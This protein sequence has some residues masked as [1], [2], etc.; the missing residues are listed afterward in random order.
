MFNKMRFILS[1]LCIVLANRGLAQSINI[2]STFTYAQGEG[3]F[4]N[5]GKGEGTKINLLTTTQ[6]GVQYT[7]IPSLVATPN[8][9]RMSLNLVRIAVAASTYKNKITMGLV[10]DFTGTTPILEAWAGYKL[11]KQAKIIFGQKQTHT[12]NRLAMEDE[13]FAQVMSQSI[14]GTSSDGIMYGGLMHNFVG[15]TREAGLYVETNFNVGKMRVYP[16]ASL[17]TGRGQNF[18]DAYTQGGYK[19]GGRLDIMPLGDFIKNNAF[20][21]HDIYRE[22]KPRLALGVAASVNVNASNADGSSNPNVVGIF[23]KGGKAGFANYRKLVADAMFKYKGFAMVGEYMVGTVAGADLF[24][25]TAATNKLTEEVASGYYNL[26][27][28]FN[29]QTSY[30][31]KKGLAIDGR[32]TVVTPEFE[33]ASSRV[34]KQ[35]WVTLGINK[36]LKRNALKVGIN[37]SYIHNKGMVVSNEQWVGN[38]AVQLLL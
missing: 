29:M 24:T 19:Y 38:F 33:M 16:S 5:L 3:V 26:G 21:A 2:D 15:S 28:A 7:N 6:P 11:S 20:I 22:M 10:T 37:V 31:F 32:F 13:R 36:Y 23:K 9:T 34:N 4:I 27:S 8:S 1:G 14:G 12:N 30:V 17:T 18:F 25:N 35:D